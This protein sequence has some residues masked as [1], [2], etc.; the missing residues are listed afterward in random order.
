MVLDEP[1]RSRSLTS[2]VVQ[3]DTAL[4]SASVDV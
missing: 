1:R 2:A 4:P 3:A